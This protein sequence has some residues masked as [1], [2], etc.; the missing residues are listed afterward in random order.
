MKRIMNDVALATISYVMNPH[1]KVR[2]VDFETRDAMYHNRVRC[3]NVVYEGTVYGLSDYRLGKY[4]DA[5]VYGMSIDDDVI[6]FDV[7]TKWEQY[8]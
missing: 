4:T 3:G 5:K 8:K 7:M 1:Q 6:V 2:I